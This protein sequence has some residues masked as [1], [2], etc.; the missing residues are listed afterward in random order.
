MSFVLAYTMTQSSFWPTNVAVSSSSPFSSVVTP[1]TFS[2]LTSCFLK[3]PFSFI[4]LKRESAITVTSLFV[5]SFLHHHFQL[6]CWKKFVVAVSIVF[7]LLLDS[8]SLSLLV[9]NLLSLCNTNWTSRNSIIP[10]FLECKDSRFQV[11]KLRFNL[12]LKFPK[13]IQF[14]DEFFH[15][16]VV[17]TCIAIANTSALVPFESIFHIHAR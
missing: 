14:L 2:I 8:V 13:I 1:G 7:W 9:S 15:T 17:I 11:K 4:Q 6:N 3:K 16:K 10:S 5:V 12:S